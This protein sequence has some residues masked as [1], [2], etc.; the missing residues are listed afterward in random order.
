MRWS[1]SVCDRPGVR[2]ERQRGGGQR[3]A[4]VS[5]A[6]EADVPGGS[7]LRREPQR[8]P[9]DL[10]LQPGDDAAA[11]LG[12]DRVPGV[13]GRRRLA[14]PRPPRLMRSLRRP[15]TR[16]FDPGQ[17]A[18]SGDRIVSQLCLLRSSFTVGHKIPDQIN[19][20]IN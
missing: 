12:A 4:G 20:I 5:V 7:G 16:R 10:S 14:L 15:R 18:A 1:S 3:S 17:V 9:A 8:L 13:S 6:A 19:K 11:Q 2:G